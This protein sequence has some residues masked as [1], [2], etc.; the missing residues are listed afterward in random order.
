[1]SKLIASLAL[2]AVLVAPLSASAA[3]TGMHWNLGKP[4]VATCADGKTLNTNGKVRGGLLSI[5]EHFRR[6]QCVGK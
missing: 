2:A 3:A 1:M 5:M 4:V 6:S